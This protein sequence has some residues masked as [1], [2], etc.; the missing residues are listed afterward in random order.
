MNRTL[1]DRLVKELRLANISDMEAGNAFVPA[2]IERYNDRF[3]VTPTRPENRHRPVSLAANRLNDVL[4]K[5]E[6]RYVGAQLT[7]SYERKRI[8]LEENDI[9]RGLVG[10]YVETYAYA[11][12]RLDIRWKGHSLP[13]RTFDK[14]QSV[15]HAAVVEN[16]RLSDVLAYIKDQQDRHHVG[17]PK[18]NSNKNGY[19]PTGRK[20]GRRTDFM[21]DPDVIAR[22][23]K[24]LAQMDAAE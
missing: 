1:Q 11:D 23:Q 4:C 5:R 3:A 20:P 16:K 2:F 14:D 22:R 10:K 18:T 21:N 6:Q 12:G 13:H 17:K 19:K 7:F 9:T 24:A 15:T 8:M